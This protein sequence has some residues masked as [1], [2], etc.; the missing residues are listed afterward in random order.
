MALENDVQNLTKAIAVLAAAV[1][2]QTATYRTSEK[3][4]TKKVETKPETLVVDVKVQPKPAEAPTG[5]TVTL[6]QLAAKFT[7]LVEADRPAAVA[8]LSKYNIPKLGQAKEATY[9]DIFSD[10]QAALDGLA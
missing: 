6:P 1:A 8:L 5:I 9:A 4:P 3:A 7:D 10:V 2:E